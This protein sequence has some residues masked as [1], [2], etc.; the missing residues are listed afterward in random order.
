MERDTPEPQAVA[1]KE[2][3]RSRSVM[4]RKRVKLLRGLAQG[5][6]ISEAGREAGYYNRQ[7][8]HRAYERLKLQIPGRLNA[9]GCPVDK[10]L[11]KLISKLDAKETKFFQKDGVVIETRQVA[12]HDVQLDASDKLLRLFNA[13]PSNRGNADADHDTVSG[14]S[15]TVVIADPD[16]ARAIMERLESSGQMRALEPVLDALRN[17]N[18]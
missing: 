16:R 7:S 6:N 5:M 3:R 17:E 18:P 11:T 14:P 13:Y 8:A 2:R 15:F 12:A 10:V 1:K 9:L 4:N